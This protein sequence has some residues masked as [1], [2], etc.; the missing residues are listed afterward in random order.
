ML[1]YY[2]PIAS[3]SQNNTTDMPCFCE[4]FMN[5]F[6]IYYGA[7]EEVH[8]FGMNCSIRS[9]ALEVEPQRMTFC[10]VPF[11]NGELSQIS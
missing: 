6:S 3:T 11:F 10:I 8:T 1:G 4:Y 9:A 5:L 2:S 7:A